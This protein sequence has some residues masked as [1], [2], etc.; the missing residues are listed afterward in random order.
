[1]TPGSPSVCWVKADDQRHQVARKMIS[2][3]FAPAS[4]SRRPAAQFSTKAIVPA[5]CPAAGMVS[6]SSRRLIGSGQRSLAGWVVRTCSSR[7]SQP[8]ATTQ[9]AA[10]SRRRRCLGRLVIGK[11]GTNSVVKN[12]SSRPADGVWRTLTPSDFLRQPGPRRFAN[13]RWTRMTVAA[14]PVC[15]IRRSGR[16]DRSADLFVQR[17]CFWRRISPTVTGLCHDSSLAP[18]FFHGC[19][20]RSRRRCSSAVG[21]GG[22]LS[23]GAPQR[24]RS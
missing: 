4:A 10:G 14:C 22:R 12:G 11:A 23:A 17:R 18:A 8:T 20:M 15:L 7:I 6:A 21:C 5:V 9:A 3:G 1:M 13:S 16:Q 24:A 2:S 19:P